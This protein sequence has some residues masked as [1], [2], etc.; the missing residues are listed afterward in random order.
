MERDGRDDRR[1]SRRRSRSRS[2]SL[3]GRRR[4][5][6]G[7]GAARGSSRRSRSRSRTRST[8]RR[9]HSDGGRSKNA[10]PQAEPAAALQPAPQPA[11]PPP[12]DPGPAPTVELVA[13]TRDNLKLLMA[14]RSDLEAL[15][16]VERLLVG[17]PQPAGVMVQLFQPGLL[18][19]AGVWFASLVDRS[20]NCVACS[21]VC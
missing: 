21:L 19:P 2:R 1:Q 15:R 11:A 10:R 16:E 13:P 17:E 9:R 14:T 7:G 3:E 20:C 18:P 6:S 8:E 4:R 12:A 5:S